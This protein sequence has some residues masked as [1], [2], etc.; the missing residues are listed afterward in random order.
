MLNVINPKREEI[1]EIHSYF[2]LNIPSCFFCTQFLMC[3]RERVC[4]EPSGP[5]YKHHSTTGRG[6]P[7]S[8]I[9]RMLYLPCHINTPSSHFFA[10]SIASNTCVIIDEWYDLSR[11]SSHLLSEKVGLDELWGS[12]PVFLALVFPSTQHFHFT[13]PQPPHLPPR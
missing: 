2:H 6:R 10:I 12:L 5:S 8:W 1:Q 3:Q 4:G 7:F 13:G 9:S 11:L